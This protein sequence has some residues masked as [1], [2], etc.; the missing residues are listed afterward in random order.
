M[1]KPPKTAN[2]IV[3]KA[4]VAA[5]FNVSLP[6]V[7]AWQRRGAPIDDI[8]GTDLGAVEL[9]RVFQ[10]MAQ[11]NK[12]WRE[13]VA[14]PVGDLIDELHAQQGRLSFFVNHQ[15]WSHPRRAEIGKH[16]LAISTAASRLCDI[17]DA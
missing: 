14:R 8:G 15:H 5:H 11:T 1:K 3:T 9:W 12:F 7:A 6:T 2:A 10:D 17:L 4:A 13:L 16:L